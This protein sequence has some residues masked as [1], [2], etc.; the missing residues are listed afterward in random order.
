MK[1]DKIYKI[2]E[3]NNNLLN[4]RGKV[5]LDRYNTLITNDDIYL[6]SSACH[7]DQGKQDINKS[8]DLFR[9]GK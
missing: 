5:Y 9:E 3:N 4:L 1:F 6:L 7:I 8:M 2:T